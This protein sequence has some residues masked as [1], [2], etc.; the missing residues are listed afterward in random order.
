MIS[1]EICRSLGRTGFDD[2]QVN[3]QYG[4]VI[5]SGYVDSELEKAR[6]EEIA[7]S[8]AGVLAVKNEIVV[9]KRPPVNVNK[10]GGPKKCS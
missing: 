6:A 2:V 5:L 8:T 3:T 7:K 9:F 10:R 4:E 1:S